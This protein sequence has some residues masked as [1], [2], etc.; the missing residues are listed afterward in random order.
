MHQRKNGFH[1]KNKNKLKLDRL[2]SQLGEIT[3][4]GYE[5]GEPRYENGSLGIPIRESVD[6]SLAVNDF[7]DAVSRDVQ[8]LPVKPVIEYRQSV[9]AVIMMPASDVPVDVR[10]YTSRFLEAYGIILNRYRKK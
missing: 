8:R 5:I 2:L 9:S 7:R 10:N 6:M 4:V 1:G 3:D